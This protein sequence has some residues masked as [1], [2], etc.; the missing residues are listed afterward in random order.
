MKNLI[1]LVALIFLTVSAFAQTQWKA[2]PYHSSLNFEILHS[3]ISIVNGKFLE[4]TGNLTTDGEALNNANFDVV[5]K[6]KSI[7]TNVEKRDNHLR[8]ADFFEVEKFPDMTFKSTKIVATDTPDQYLLYGDLTIKDVTKEVIFDVYYGGT[9]KSDQGEK[10]GL[11]ATTTINRFDYNIDYDP[12]AAGVGK[13]VNI[14][15]HGQF[16]KQ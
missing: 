14:V 13:D 11:K 6:V 4:Y 16:V 8:S 1:S 10:L 9:A 15:V 7:N 3:G 5:I 12:S 2:D